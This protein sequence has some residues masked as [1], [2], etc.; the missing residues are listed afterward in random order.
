MGRVGAFVRER[1]GWATHFEPFLEKPV[2][3]DL[4]WTFTL[5]S[6]CAL[7]FVVETL[8]GMLLALYY[9][10]SPDHAYESILY[11]MEGVAGGRVIRGIHHWGAGAMVI[12]VFAHM[13]TTFYYGAYKPP[14]EMT[15][16][17]GVGLLLLTL[18]F[19]FTGY[20]L[21]WDQKAFWATVV[22]TSVPSDIPLIG[23]WITRL[24][25][26]GEELSGL[27]LTRF[28]AVH[29]LV[30][31]ALT[32]TLTGGH[33]YLVRLHDVAGHWDPAHPGKA[34]SSRFFPDH[35]MKSALAF[36]FA[37]ALV[38][39]MAVFVD[40]PMDEKA[41]TPDPSYLPR[42]EWYYM[43]LFKMLTYFS[44]RAEVLGSLIIPLGG[45]LLLLL[46]PFLNDRPERSPAARPLAMAL[47]ATCL[48]GL[49]FLSITGINDSRPY[50]RLIVVPD[51]SL[52]PNEAKGLRLWVEKDC[53]YCHNIL[54]RGG[55]QEGPDLSNVTR[56]GRDRAW[57]VKLIRD[58][59][60]V[61][62]WSIMPKYDLNESELHALAEFVLSLDF[63][64][65][66]ARMVSREDAV[67]GKRP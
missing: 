23:E 25:R 36:A 47:G 40:P 64:R 20:L 15:W 9:N 14:R 41:L 17:F 39:G 35:V 12:L 26:G 43:W 33:I 4:N 13:A 11:I 8:T 67:G 60:A 10:P 30:L 38:L 59:Q 63:R 58:P 29:M 46:L 42:P 24:L 52:T 56:R 57:L 49:V 55:R 50:G 34:K 37:F 51:R 31:P 61:S 48:A 21:P 7:L 65:H 53:A 19:G 28:Y 6:L 62:G 32:L 54:G 2:S 66:G 3:G 27:T 18:A 16:V 5:G 22:G 45:L 44:G 1:F